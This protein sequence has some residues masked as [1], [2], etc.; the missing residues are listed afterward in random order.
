MLC[1]ERQ[2]S[3]LSERPPPRVAV[4]FSGWVYFPRGVHR[5]RLSE[6]KVFRAWKFNPCK[7]S[8]FTL[9]RN[10]NHLKESSIAVRGKKAGNSISVKSGRTLPYVRTTTSEHVNRQKRAADDRLLR[11][12]GSGCQSCFVLPVRRSRVVLNIPHTWGGLTTWI[13]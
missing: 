8:P 3:S 4:L 6:F 5:F 11:R 9:G 12:L 1:F 10:E 7:I 2:K 13:S